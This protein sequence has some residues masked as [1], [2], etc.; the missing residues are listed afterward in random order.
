MRCPGCGKEIKPDAK[1]CKYCGEPIAVQINEQKEDNRKTNTKPSGKRWITL[2]L[3]VTFFIA[4]FLI[5]AVGLYYVKSKKEVENRNYKREN[6]TT[7]STTAEENSISGEI[8]IP[9]EE[10]GT[11]EDASDNL[12]E[13][14]TATTEDNDQLPYTDNAYI[15]LSD[16][17]EPA[18]LKYKTSADGSFSFAYPKYLF[19]TSNADNANNS[20]ELSYVDDNNDTILSL[21]IYTEEN[22]GDVLTNVS[23]LYDYYISQIMEVSYEHIPDKVD[24]RGMARALLGGYQDKNKTK[25]VYIIAANDGKKNYI[26]EINFPEPD[27]QNDYDEINYVVDCLYRA[28]SFSGTSYKPRTFDQFKKDEWG[29]KK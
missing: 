11:M 3:V 27:Y 19:N 5:A 10:N 29:E 2:F 22:Q 12:T 23:N 1:F 24:S 13:N 14:I 28:C 15:N 9:K 21:H 26:M 16:C 18:C 7:E 20:Y 17:M 25:G 6:V 8:G 4:L